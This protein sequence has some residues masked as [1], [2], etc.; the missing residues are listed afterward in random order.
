[1]PLLRLCSAPN[2]GSMQPEPRCPQHRQRTARQRGYSTRWD[3]IAR[4][5]RRANP[6]CAVCAR[7]ATVVDHI[8]S[9]RAGGSDEWRNLQS[10]C[11]R[12]HARK[13]ASERG[14]G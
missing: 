6:L 13:T 14:L 8:I 3:Q 5:Y 4:A 9:K 1:M 7:P 10:M 11:A 2:C 12:C